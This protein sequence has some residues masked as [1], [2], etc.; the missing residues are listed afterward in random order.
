MAQINKPG[1]HFNTVLYTGTGSAQSITGVGFQPDFVWLKAR[2][3]AYFLG[4]GGFV[5]KE[6]PTSVVTSVLYSY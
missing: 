5:N 1:L 6:F 4:A 3:A 2:N